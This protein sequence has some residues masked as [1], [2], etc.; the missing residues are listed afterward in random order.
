LAR[1]SGGKG[2]DLRAWG[3]ARTTRNARPGSGRTSPG[4]DDDGRACLVEH[5]PIM[6]FDPVPLTA[7]VA[8]REPNTLVDHMW[9]WFFLVSSLFW[10]RICLLTFWIFGDHFLR[11]AFDGKWAIPIAGF[12]LMPWTTMVYALMWGFTSDGVFGFEWFFVG[13]AV[14]TDLA[15]WAEGRR[16]FR[17]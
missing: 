13:L 7:D 9:G 1:T 8:R 4:S 5:R 6:P 15:T 14:L 17:G 16:L 12:F 11:D 10:P 2:A 3:E